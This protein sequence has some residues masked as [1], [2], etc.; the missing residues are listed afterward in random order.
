[1]NTLTSHK[2]PPCNN[3][4]HMDGAWRPLPMQ[5]LQFCRVLLHFRVAGRSAA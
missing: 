5:G 4:F 3:A 1:M 2:L